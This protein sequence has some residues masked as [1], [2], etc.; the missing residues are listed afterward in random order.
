MAVKSY[1]GR[2]EIL[3]SSTVKNDRHE[4]AEQAAA[5][6]GSVFY[7]VGSAPFTGWKGLAN[8]VPSC[9]SL[10]KNIYKYKVDT[11]ESDKRGEVDQLR[12]RDIIKKVVVNMVAE[13]AAVGVKHEVKRFAE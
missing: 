8:A 6:A 7:H 5:A 12:K 2:V 11:H 4:H 3:P 1:K 10:A 9:C 13:G